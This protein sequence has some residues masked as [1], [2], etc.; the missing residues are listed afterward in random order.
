[1]KLYKSTFAGVYL[2]ARQSHNAAFRVSRMIVPTNG[3]YVITKRNPELCKGVVIYFNWDVVAYVQTLK[4]AGDYIDNC[5]D[6]HGWKR[7]LAPT[8]KGG[9]A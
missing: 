7:A 5:Y 2:S 6:P 1:V 3:K 8:K 9:A 4:E